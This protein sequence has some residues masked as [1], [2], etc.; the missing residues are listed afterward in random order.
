MKLGKELPDSKYL[1]LPCGNCLGCR[2]SK[3]K[4]WALRCTLEL[5]QHD[6]AVFTTLTYRD[7][8][9][10]PT[11]EPRRLQ[12]WLKRL[13][14]E[15]GPARP[16]RFF[17]SGEY[18]EQTERPHYHGIIY[19]LKPQDAN[20][21]EDTWGAGGCRTYKV[22][23]AAI[24]YTAGY[25]AKK[26]GYA[27]RASEERVDLDTG[28]VYQWQP[29][30]IRMS[31]RPGLGGHAREW[32]NSWRLYAIHNGYR[33]PV[34]RFLHESWKATAT[35]EEIEDLIT[36]KSQLALR[37]DTSRERLQAAELIAAAKQ[38]MSGERRKL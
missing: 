31:R 4:S 6:H 35:E 13:R 15:M 21:I 8:T 19:G 11:L 17:A 33:M 25:S 34:P 22:T 1:R 5:Q 24:S 27:R 14:K 36:E 9:L 38:R 16:I 12:L 28:E 29:P 3:A 20:V 37:R 32:R 18:G 7:E 30:F 10:P 26:I 23:P 2:A